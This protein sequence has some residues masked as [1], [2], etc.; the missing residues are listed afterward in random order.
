MIPESN[1]VRCAFSLFEKNAAAP[2]IK[3]AIPRDIHAAISTALIGSDREHTIPPDASTSTHDAISVTARVRTAQK[4]VLP[5]RVSVEPK[6]DLLYFCLA[7]FPPK[8]TVFSI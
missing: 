2:P 8:K 1:A 6:F 3:E 5:S 4:N 7:I